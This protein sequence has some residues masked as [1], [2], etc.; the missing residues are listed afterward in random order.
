MSATPIIPNEN[1]TSHSSARSNLAIRAKHIMST[2]VTIVEPDTT[3]HKIAQLLND[4]HISAVMV[5]DR[6]ALV[7]IVS[8][9]DLLNRVEL[10]HWLRKCVVARAH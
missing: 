1:R 10:G 5:I 3:V 8:E 4:R 6:G 2:N 7:G 9:G